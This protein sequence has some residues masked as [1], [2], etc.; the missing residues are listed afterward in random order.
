MNRNFRIGC[1]HSR[2]SFRLDVDLTL[3]PGST[4]G[5]F[6]ASGAGKTTLLRCIA[7]L[8]RPDTATIVI[9]G[10]EWQTASMFMAPH[11]RR[12]AFVFQEP[13]LFPG[14]VHHNLLYA[15]KRAGGQRRTIGAVSDALDLGPLLRRDVHGLSGGESKRVAIGR[16]LLSSPHLLLMDEPTASLDLTRR[17]ELLPYFARLNTLL[18]VPVIYVSHSLDE[19]IQIA[20]T[21]LVLVDGEVRAH[22]PLQQVVA[23]A[24]LPGLDGAEAG[25][26]IE[27][28][29]VDAAAE[30][31]LRRVAFGGGQLWVAAQD[32]PGR[33]RLR[34][35]ANDVSVCRSRP[36]DSS[37]LNLLDARIVD[38]QDE[39]EVAAMLRLR[40]GDQELLSRITQQ[41]RHRLELKVGETVVAQIK[42][43]AVR[44][45]PVA[46]G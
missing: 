21:M 12:V 34:I 40:V 7:G 16:A 38:I 20:D 11:D 44:G 17:H 45:G 35:R 2:G 43:V 4:L 27:G 29:A 36:L 22:G 18:D 9:G 33:P 39:S 41:S 5:V 28:A 26:V 15:Y 25:V 23:D 1:T 42:S 30:R 10:V 14:T 37:V 31:G 24:S 6:G 46:T 13:R 19:L 8:E 32:L 3:E